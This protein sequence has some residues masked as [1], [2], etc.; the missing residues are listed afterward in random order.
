MAAGVTQ[1]LHWGKQKKTACKRKMGEMR[2]AEKHVSFMLAAALNI[3]SAATAT[4]T[5]FFCGETTAAATTTA[6]EL[7]L[8]GASCCHTLPSCH[9]AV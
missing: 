2:N 8:H 1:V 6:K 7:L 4:R 9:A 3:I 5:H